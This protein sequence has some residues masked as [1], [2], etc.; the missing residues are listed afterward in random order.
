MLH[1]INI[2]L[3][4]KESFLLF[5]TGMSMLITPGTAGSMIKSYILKQKI[6]KTISST[7]PI[8]LYEK[9]LELFS[10]IIVIGILLFFTNFWES[11]IVFVVGMIAII[12]LFV[13][14]KYS[15]GIDTI[16]KLISKLRLAKNLKIDSEEFK[17]TTTKLTNF[18]IL[19][20]LLSLS[21]FAQLIVIIVVYLIFLSLDLTFDIFSSGQIYLTSA[22]IG[23]LSMI[24]GGVV[25]TEAGM[26]GFLL[27]N[28]VEFSVAS[29]TVLIIR[30]VTFWFP[31]I[32]GYIA[33]KWIS[34]KNKLGT[35]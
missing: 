13:L 2:N 7:A 6:N 1:Q 34:G 12:F 5:M 35:I 11:K 21:V 28:N 9:W 18:K 30:G 8:V 15:V 20:T 24:P 4:F 26:I 3:K 19:I 22:L 14:F 32:L 29:I 25:V 10:M 27:N 23:F 31:M 17:Q 33:L 16:N